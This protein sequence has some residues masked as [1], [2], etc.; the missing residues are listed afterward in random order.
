M[1]CQNNKLNIKTSNWFENRTEN[2]CVRAD[3]WRKKAE[4]EDKDGPG[5]ADALETAMHA[6][7]CSSVTTSTQTRSGGCF[8]GVIRRR[9][10]ADGPAL[11]FGVRLD[12]P[13]RSVRR[14]EQTEQVNYTAPTGFSSAPGRNN[15]GGAVRVVIAQ[16][17]S[18]YPVINSSRDRRDANSII[19]L[20]T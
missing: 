1:P 8:H 4:E 2:I 15:D 14:R 10:D 12:R 6:G 9:R 11:T 3:K 16:R 18:N 5:Q 13:L 7:M 19:H 17:M 20:E